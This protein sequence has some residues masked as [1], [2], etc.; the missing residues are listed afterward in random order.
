MAFT[1]SICATRK[2]CAKAAVAQI[3]CDDLLRCMIAIEV[4]NHFCQATNLSRPS[5]EHGL[6]TVHLCMGCGQL[7]IAFFELPELDCCTVKFNLGFVM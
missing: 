3:G 6:F 1:C 4:C 7:L 5:L 2:A